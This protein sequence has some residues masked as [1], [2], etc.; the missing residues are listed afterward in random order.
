MAVLQDI[1]RPPGG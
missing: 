1:G